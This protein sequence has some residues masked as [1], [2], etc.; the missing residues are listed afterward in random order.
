MIFL[1]EEEVGPEVLK[2]KNQIMYDNLN[3]IQLKMKVV[4]ERV[5]SLCKG[6]FKV[7]GVQIV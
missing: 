7:Q 4:K 2:I 3:Q 6:F 1:E 5:K